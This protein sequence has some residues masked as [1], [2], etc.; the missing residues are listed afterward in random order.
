MTGKTN[1]IS[2]SSASLNFTVVGGTT[3]PASPTENMIWVNTSYSI[4]NYAL[5]PDDPGTLIATTTVDV[6][7]RN[8]PSTDGNVITI[9]PQY[10][11]CIVSDKSSNWYLV[12]YSG[13]VGWI[14]GTYL[15]LSTVANDGMV[16]IKTAD[17]GKANINISSNP[18]ITIKAGTVLQ[19][20]NGAWAGKNAFIYHD[21]AWQQLVTWAYYHGE[22]FTTFTGGFTFTKNSNGAYADHSTDGGYLYLSDT[23]GTA[24]R[25]STVYTVNQI[26]G[27]HFSRLHAKVIPKRTN[28]GYIKIAA[29]TQNTVTT[30]LAGLTSTLA[31]ETY[32]VFDADTEMEISVDVSNID[33]YY[34]AIQCQ[35]GSRPEIYE[36]WFT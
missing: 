4:S 36:I 18:P 1:A 24:A 29:T 21:S 10:T 5:A 8:W 32:Q 7:M 9:V 14:D 20:W 25:F 17:S 26:S 23:G 31:I 30:T 33:S 27:M 2:A 16:W 3:E 12:T 22:K 13:M 11:A 28:T 35:N 6:N 19:F 34:I 15:T